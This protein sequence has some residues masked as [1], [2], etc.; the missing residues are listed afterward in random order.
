MC[1]I[2]LQIAYSVKNH[3]KY[4]IV[5]LLKLFI[6]LQGSRILEPHQIIV[7]TWQSYLNTQKEIITTLS[8]ENYSFWQRYWFLYWEWLF[9]CYQVIYKTKFFKTNSL[10]QREFWSLIKILQII[11]LAIYFCHFIYS[12]IFIHSLYMYIIVFSEIP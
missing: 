3:I 10:K 5:N 11:L 1:L 9:L 6:Y 7:R 4:Y 2:L 12:F 8:I